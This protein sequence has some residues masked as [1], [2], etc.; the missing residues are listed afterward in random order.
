MVEESLITDEARAMIGKETQ[1]VKG[2]EVA[3][4]EV[5]RYC[6]AVDDLNPLYI[7]GEQAEKGPYK[8]I[9]APPNFHIVP[10]AV[11]T[12]LSSLRK[13]GIPNEQAGILSLKVSRIMYGGCET[14][15]LKSVRPGD[16]L[17]R[18]SK[19]TEIYERTSRSG[20]K[21]V[22]T[23]LETRYSNQTGEVV[24]IDR[25]TTISH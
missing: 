12:P 18:K 1:P 9:I 14:E 15:F 16:L 17:T 6:E 21:M 7:D 19:F 11:P 13:D 3:E 24:A 20:D 23:V 5:R 4:H 10:F 22:F 8:G 2:Y 25:M